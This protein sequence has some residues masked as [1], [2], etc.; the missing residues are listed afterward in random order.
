[1]SYV[2]GFRRFYDGLVTI[3][4]IRVLSHDFVNTFLNILCRARE[5]SQ[6][7]TKNSKYSTFHQ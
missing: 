3:L 2:T 4:H 6:D 7:L 1:M 5:M